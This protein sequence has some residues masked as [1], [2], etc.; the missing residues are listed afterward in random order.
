NILT[1]YGHALTRQNTIKKVFRKIRA[2]QNPRLLPCHPGRLP[3]PC[4]TSVQVCSTLFKIKKSSRKSSG[5]ARPPR[6]QNGLG[7]WPTGT[8]S[9]IV[10]VVQ[11]VFGL[12]QNRSI[13]HF[14]RRALCVAAL[15]AAAFGPA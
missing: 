11:S 15:F 14:A 4:S 13:M 2:P 12:T 6:D 1:R 8:G 10:P 9:A 3:P 7:R 5:P